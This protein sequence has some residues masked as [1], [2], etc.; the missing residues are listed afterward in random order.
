[1]SLKDTLQD[2]ISVISGTVLNRYRLALPSCTSLLDVEHFTGTEGM[3]FTATTSLLQAAIV[4][5]Y[6]N[7]E[8]GKLANRGFHNHSSQTTADISKPASPTE[9][10]NVYAE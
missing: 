8:Q 5:S 3:S 4:E 9:H 7:P 10:R 2:A 1:M 6:S